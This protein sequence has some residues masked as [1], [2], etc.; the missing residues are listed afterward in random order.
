MKIAFLIIAHNHPYH[1]VRTIRKLISKDSAFFIHID[2]K[3]NLSEFVMEL[4]KLKNLADIKLLPRF[5][6]YWGGP[7]IIYAILSGL[8][9]ILKVKKFNRIV[10][11]SGQ[12]YPI[13]SPDY[14]FDFF[15]RHDKNNYFR[16]FKLPSEEW[17]LGGLNR[18]KS[19]HFRLLGK[20]YIYPPIHE[21]VDAYAKLF[22]KM[23]SLRFRQ[24]RE[25]P[26]ELQPFGGYNWWKITPDAAQEILNFIHKRPDYLKFHKYTL[27]PDEI[28]FQTILLNSKN[29]S[30]L[31]S[32]VDEDLVHQK[33][34]MG[35][36]HPE[37]LT[38]SD[39]DAIK[40]STA[41][42]ARKFDLR[43]SSNVLDM[44]DNLN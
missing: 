10:L 7:G 1:L 34:N 21:P 13:K 32:I 14:I 19:Y 27:I 15:N 2:K 29:D 12:D 16:Y 44:I 8:N 11:M 33:W 37:I 6:S 22:Y 31:N 18:I 26:K 36:P 42:F 5:N 39:I 23:V 41:L 24:P 35:E 17:A 40:N 3:S 25:F 43:T 38:S 9:E 20:T 4:S 30:L 28:F